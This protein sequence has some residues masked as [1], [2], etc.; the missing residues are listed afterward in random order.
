MS[1]PVQ[2]K[3]RHFTAHLFQPSIGLTPTNFLAELPGEFLPIDARGI[4]NKALYQL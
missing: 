4:G 1:G 2:A 3:K